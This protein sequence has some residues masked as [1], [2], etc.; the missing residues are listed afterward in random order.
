MDEHQEF[1]H[2]EGAFSEETSRALETLRERA[3]E[4]RADEAARWLEI[5]SRLKAS[6]DTIMEELTRQKKAY[7]TDQEKTKSQTAEL[8]RRETELVQLKTALSEREAAIAS[9]EAEMDR[10]HEELCLLMNQRA[11]WEARHEEVLAARQE[12]ESIVSERDRLAKDLAE[13]SKRLDEA[14]RQQESLHQEI[15]LVKKEL[16]SAVKTRDRLASVL[17]ETEE[18][19]E[20]TAQ[21]LAAQPD[22]SELQRKFEL[23]MEEARDLRA[24]NAELAEQLASRPDSKSEESQEVFNLRSQRDALIQQ[25]M[26][27]ERKVAG[28]ADATLD[29]QYDDLQRRFEI[30]VEEVRTLKTEKSELENRLKEIDSDE[31]AEN[32][33]PGNGLDWESIKRSLL[34][35]LDDD[36]NA[37]IEEDRRERA[38]IEGAIQITDEVVAKKDQ[39][40]AELTQLLAEQSSKIGEVAV[41]AGAV[42][43]LFDENEAIRMERERL[44][45]LQV[46]WEEKLR[47]AELEF[48][49]QRAKFAREKN[50][51]E[52]RQRE[53]DAARAELEEAMH[54]A[55]GQISYPKR[56]WLSRLGLNKED[57]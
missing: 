49:I 21:R 44:R 45:E 14:V 34:R 18:N 6:L 2:Y 31:V 22:T 24:M 38:T 52:Q 9:H 23:A 27:L 29:E 28:D 57:E 13:M 51:L 46:E 12:I 5:E 3:N 55:P 40:I 19:L 36:F 1:P 15:N 50:D 39:E 16:E 37:S 56:R 32:W 11:E 10:L 35:N 53:M 8:E 48:S 54:A 25:V 43:E 41:G 47:Q 42:A 30:A 4:M 26:E 20:Q 17:A 33:N 7:S